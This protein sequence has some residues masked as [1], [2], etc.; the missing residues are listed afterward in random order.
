MKASIMAVSKRGVL[1]IARTA[2]VDTGFMRT[3]AP[4]GSTMVDQTELSAHRTKIL[5]TA[6]YAPFVDDGDGG[7][8][9]GAGFSAR[10]RDELNRQASKVF[11][12]RFLLPFGGGGGGEGPS[13]EAQASAG[14][15]R[16][17]R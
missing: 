17:F 4:A 9:R 11:R 14:G 2:P 3:P 15:R 7:R 6:F 1:I 13:V 8:K 10:A 5:V 16:G 12:D